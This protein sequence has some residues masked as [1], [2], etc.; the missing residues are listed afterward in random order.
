MSMEKKG[1]GALLEAHRIRLKMTLRDFCR[2]AEADPANISRMERG[3]FPPP[4]NGEILERY[5][6][7][8][9]LKKGADD[10]IEFFDQAAADQGVIPAD[11]L[12][13]PALV[14]ALPMFFRTLRG[15]KPTKQEM[16]R[17]A[18]KIKRHG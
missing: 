13:E 9:G 6:K 11:I 17:V 14:R 15:Q 7:A 2:K 18:E 16:R 3:A 8:L 12:G 5:A 10:W 4:K 1:F